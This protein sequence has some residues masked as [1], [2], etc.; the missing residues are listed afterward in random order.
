MDER[1]CTR[2]RLARLAPT[3]AVC[4]RLCYDMMAFCSLSYLDAPSCIWISRCA[5]S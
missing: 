5:L 4:P 1:F 2:G 3:A